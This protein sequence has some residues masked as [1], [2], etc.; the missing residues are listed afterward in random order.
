MDEVHSLLWSLSVFCLTFFTGCAYF[1]IGAFGEIAPLRMMGK[2]SKDFI[3]DLIFMCL[4]FSVALGLPIFIAIRG[5]KKKSLTVSGAALGVFLAFFS[6]LCHWSY[7]TALMS[8]FLTSS[9]ATRYKSEVKRL[10]E[11]ENFKQGGQRNWIQ[12]FC[13][14]GVAFLITLMHLVC[15]GPGRD[16]PIDFSV[17]YR[18]SYLGSAYLGAMAA[19][20]GDTWA[21]ELGSVWCKSDPYLITTL[22]KVPKGT[23]GGVSP[24]GLVFSFF[25]GMTVGLAYYLP[26]YFLHGDLPAKQ[27]YVVVLGGLCGLLGSLIDSWM[28]ATLQFSGFHRE[29]KYVVEE[30][31][32]DIEPI[33]GSQILDNHS[34]NLFSSML[35]AIATPFLGNLMF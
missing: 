27:L 17:N 22:Q 24:A 35:T 30:P 14:G 15:V 18:A 13:N 20:N 10:I 2:T 25:G 32:P 21:S 4:D 12:V 31:G 28:G 33:C 19:C 7:L 34:V 26:L 1:I 3:G 29:K 5:L 23:N 9:K 16:L 6:I 8:F 11:G